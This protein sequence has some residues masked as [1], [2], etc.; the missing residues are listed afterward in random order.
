MVKARL[1]EHNLSHA[2]GGQ[3]GVQIGS[4]PFSV[5]RTRGSQSQAIAPYRSFQTPT[6]GG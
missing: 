1:V 3:L 5:S 4:A 6:K 2:H